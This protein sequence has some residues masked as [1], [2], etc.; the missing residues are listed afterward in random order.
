M[1][2][3]YILK[4]RRINKNGNM[5]LHISI[6]NIDTSVLEENERTVLKKLLVKCDLSEFKRNKYFE[7]KR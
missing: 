1:K 2:I 7:R 4:K 5:I 6:D 3:Y